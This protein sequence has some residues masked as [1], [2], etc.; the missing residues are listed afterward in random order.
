MRNNTK[1]DSFTTQSKIRKGNAMR[2]TQ[3][4][5][6]AALNLIEYGES[7]STARKITHI[8]KSILAREMRKRKNTKAR[9][10]IGRM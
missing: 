7:F 10:I 3:A 1:I 2:Y 8:N 9:A 5:L 4:E 6:T